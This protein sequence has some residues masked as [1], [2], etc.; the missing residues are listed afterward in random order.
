[1]LDKISQ[2][3]NCV[4]KSGSKHI[5]YKCPGCLRPIMFCHGGKEVNQFQVRNN[6]KDMGV[7]W[8]EFKEWMDN[9][10]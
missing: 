1:M 3:N 7:T 2:E 10:C 4:E 6:L 9:N 5:K 8:E